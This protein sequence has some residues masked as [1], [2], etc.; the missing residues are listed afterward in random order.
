MFQLKKNYCWLTGFPVNYSE[1]NRD[2]EAE[3]IRKKNKQNK[4]EHGKVQIE[5]GG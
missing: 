1:W 5:T 2:R 4:K 3:Y